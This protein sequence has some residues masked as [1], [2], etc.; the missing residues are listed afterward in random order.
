MAVVTDQLRKIGKTLTAFDGAYIGTTR[1]PVHHSAIYWAAF[2]RL[3][4]V[5]DPTSASVEQVLQELANS[6]NRPRVSWLNDIEWFEVDTLED[7][8]KAR[9][10]LAP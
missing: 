1:I 6:Q 7:L 8:E 3:R 9:Q 5:V 4:E 2:D 10:G